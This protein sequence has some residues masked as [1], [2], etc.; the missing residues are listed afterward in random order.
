MLPIST[1][2]DVASQVMALLSALDDWVL[3]RHQWI[4]KA[5]RSLVTG[6]NQS[7]QADLPGFSEIFPENPAIPDCLQ[8]RFASECHQLEMLWENVIAA[9]HPLSGLPLF[10][11]LDEFQLEAEKFMHQARQSSQRLWRELTLRDPLT[12]ARTRLTLKSSLQLELQRAQRQGLSC[13]LAMLDQNTFKQ[14]NDQWGH[15]AGDLV[16]AKTAKLIQDSLRPSDQLFRFGGD[17]WLLL[18]PMTS[19]DNALKLVQRICNNIGKHVFVLA[20]GSAF[21]TGLSYGISESRIDENIDD[22]IARAD[23]ALYHMKGHVRHTADIAGS[24]SAARVKAQPAAES[25]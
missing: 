1:E 16:L 12:G 18:L 25:L 19:I 3:V 7:D 9:A 23:N 6:E 4:V 14:I 15:A 22:W 11:Q 17:E 24:S 13:S 8:Q 5:M 21:T 20:D 10:Q 2:N